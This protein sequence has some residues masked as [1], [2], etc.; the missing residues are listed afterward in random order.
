MRIKPDEH[1]AIAAAIAAAEAKTSGEIFCVLARQV[2]AYR[3][4]S[5]IWAAAAALILPLGLIP[6]GFD[7]RWFPGF[8]DTWEAGHLAARDVT[9]G[10]TIG[11][12]AVVQAAVFVFSYLL[13][14]IPP[15]LRLLTPRSIRRDR[16][17]QAAMHQ[18][19]AHG[20]HVTQDRT[21]VLIFAALDD[22]QVEIIADEGIYSR[23]DPEVWAEAVAALTTG[24]KAR[25]PVEG[26]QRAIDLA[27]GV[28]AEHFPP[29]ATNHNEVPNRL[30]EI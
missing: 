16:A 6:L 4:V 15:L 19:L 12:Y 5:L 14:R 10:R 1:A 22:H 13:L 28:L 17:R 8:T 23:V 24:L 3:D 18:F 2:S 25:R 20:L 27:G 30:V 9:I 26:F 29:R 7:A 21:G 11:V